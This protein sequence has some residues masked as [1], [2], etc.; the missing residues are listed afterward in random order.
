MCPSPKKWTDPGRARTGPGLGPITNASPL[1]VTFPKATIIVVLWCL[2]F[3]HDKFENNK[4]KHIVI[5]KYFTLSLEFFFHDVEQGSQSIYSL[6]IL[7]YEV[8]VFNQ[9]TSKA[10]K[11]I[12]YS[13]DVYKYKYQKGQ[14]KFAQKTTI[15]IT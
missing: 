14:N 8:S 12:V 3:W 4:F 7:F 1:G 5:S 15:Q 10:E 9:I 11:R 13:L 6:K 2:Y